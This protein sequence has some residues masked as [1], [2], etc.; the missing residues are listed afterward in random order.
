MIV[1]R[2]NLN[3]ADIRLRPHFKSERITQT[4]FNEPLELLERLD[5]Y[6]HVRLYDRYQGYINNNFFGENPDASGKDY[7]ISAT[8]APALAKPEKNSSILA[9]LPFSAKIKA[10]SHSDNFLH[11][12]SPRYGDFYLQTNDVILPG[13]I[14]KLTSDNVSLL[15]E[16][17]RR[18][19]SVPYLWGGKSFFGFDCS[20]FTQVLFQYYGIELPRDSKDQ[21]QK[22]VEIDRYHIKP[23]DLLLFKKHVALAI[24]ESDFIHSSLSLGGVAINSIDKKSKQYLK[25][26]DFGLRTVRRV[27]ED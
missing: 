11:C 2:V 15:I 24:S 8:L 23:G 6:S 25:I 13:D 17:A 7:V 18:F 26:R 12:L 27:I 19:M 4:L 9:F 20:G 21:A 16:N 14:P 5:K 1:L 10:E 3:V 22:G